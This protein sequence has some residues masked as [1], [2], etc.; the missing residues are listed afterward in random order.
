LLKVLPP[1]PEKN[2]TP[3]LSTVIV[4]YPPSLVLFT[5]Q[6]SRPCLVTLCTMKKLIL[7]E[8]ISVDGFCADRD[9]TTGHFDGT[10]HSLASDVDAYQGTVMDS[11]DVC[12]FLARRNQRRYQ[13][14]RR[15][16][17]HSQDCV[18]P[19]TERSAAGKPRKHFP[20][21]GRCRCVYQ[22]PESR[23]RKKH[24]YVGQPV[25]CT[26]TAGSRPI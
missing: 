16:E 19:V 3:S 18:F 7:Q 14:N 17:Q 20:G 23:G 9:K 6:K 21:I 1:I 13:G 25:L 4:P 2:Y 8:F 22:T 5:Q 12:L 10:Y 26:T 11:I 24:D 15:D